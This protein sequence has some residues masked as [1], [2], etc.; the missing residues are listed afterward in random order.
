MMTKGNQLIYYSAIISAWAE[1]RTPFPLCYEGKELCARVSEQKKAERIFQN[2]AREKGLTEE[3]KITDNDICAANLSGEFNPE[4][5]FLIPA[6]YA[7][8]PVSANA[9]QS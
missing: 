6:S 1:E 9:E 8:K 4:H 5:Y 7:T 3:Y 2:F